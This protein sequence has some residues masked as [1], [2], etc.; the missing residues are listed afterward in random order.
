MVGEISAVT[1]TEVLKA[2][3][4]GTERHRRRTRAGCSTSSLLSRD[5]TASMRSDSCA[6]AKMPQFGQF[7]RD[8][9]LR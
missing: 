5:V 6:R 4:T 1:R 9:Y 2:I 7:Q 3:R 8:G